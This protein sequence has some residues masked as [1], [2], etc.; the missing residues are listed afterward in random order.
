MSNLQL[1][2]QKRTLLIASEKLGFLVYC[3][4]NVGGNF[5]T[6]PV[7]KKFFSPKFHD[8]ICNIINNKSLR[9]FQNP[10]LLI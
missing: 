5:N 4:T 2:L 1:V 3:P 8:T 9:K 6:G 7:E 10:S